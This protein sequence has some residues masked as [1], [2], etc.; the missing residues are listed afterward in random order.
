[1]FSLIFPGFEA[2]ARVK[3]ESRGTA[4]TFFS[5]LGEIFPRFSSSLI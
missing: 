3:P 4:R 5:K 2:N 1:M